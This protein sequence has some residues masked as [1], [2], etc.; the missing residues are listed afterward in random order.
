MTTTAVKC[1]KIRAGLYRDA[2]GCHEVEHVFGNWA[3]DTTRQW[4]E[5][6]LFEVV[7]GER[8]EWCSTFYT[9]RAALAACG[10]IHQGDA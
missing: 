1:R 2:D 7:D 10:R 9:R 4:D 3:G 8:G 5:W 6:R